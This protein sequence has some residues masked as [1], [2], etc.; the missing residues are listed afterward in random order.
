MR[1]AALEAA[2]N[3]TMQIRGI[4]HLSL[5]EVEGQL[6]SDARFVHF[7]YC[8]SFLILTWRMPTD[9]FLLTP[10][11]RGVFRSWPY[12]LVTFLFGWWGLPWGLYL[13]PQVLYINLCG[14]KDV[15][16][17]VWAFLQATHAVESG[18]E[19]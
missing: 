11:Q 7:E 18:P 15:T 8:V 17:E 6:R 1:R 3:S 10:R 12:L 2:Y 16:A 9:I 4:D 14:G 13:T 5:A 19:V